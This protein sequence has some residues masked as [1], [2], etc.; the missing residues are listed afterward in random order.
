L[1]GVF[2]FPLGAVAWAMGTNDL[3][4]MR[5]GFTDP[6][7]YGATAAGRAFGMAGV[8]LANLVLLAV[9]LALAAAVAVST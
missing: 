1:L 7:G 4:E 6:R 5:A 3:Y 8:V 9:L 2:C